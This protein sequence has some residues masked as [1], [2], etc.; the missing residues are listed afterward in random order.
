MA[1]TSGDV[2]TG[3]RLGR[4]GARAPPHARRRLGHRLFPAHVR[5]RRRAGRRLGESA[6]A[7]RRERTTVPRVRRRAL[8]SAC[9][10][11][12][13]LGVLRGRRSRT[14]PRAP[15][16]Q[17]PSGTRDTRRVHRGDLTQPTRRH[18]RRR[19]AARGRR[20]DAEGELSDPPRP[21]RSSHDRGRRRSLRQHPR[22]RGTSG[23]RRPGSLELDGSDGGDRR[24]SAFAHEDQRRRLSP[25]STRSSTKTPSPKPGSKAG[26]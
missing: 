18:R 25:P 22:P 8:R 5:L 3:R 23:D 6:A 14:R 17:P 15:R 12:P 20:L 19:R 13:C 26:R 4:G 16:G 21:Q 10:S 24:E 1:L 9:D 2:A 11:I 7:L